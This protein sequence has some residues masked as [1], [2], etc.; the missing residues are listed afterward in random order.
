MNVVDM[1]DHLRAIS[2]TVDKE[3]QVKVFMLTVKI[4]ASVINAHALLQATRSE[5]ETIAETGVIRQ[6]FILYFVVGHVK[7]K[8]ERVCLDPLTRK[9]LPEPNL[10][11]CDEALSKSHTLFVTK[12]RKNVYCH[13]CTLL[14]THG[15]ES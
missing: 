1:F 14:V 3:C 2:A 12:I 10:Y 11:S 7:Y 13:L 15:S 9:R 4:D 8:Q 5:G 6:R